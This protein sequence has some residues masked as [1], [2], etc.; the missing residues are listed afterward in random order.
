[1]LAGDV[2]QGVAIPDSGP[3]RPWTA[4]RLAEFAEYY[5]VL[6]RFTLRQIIAGRDGSEIRLPGA[7]VGAARAGN[8]RID[9]SYSALAARSDLSRLTGQPLQSAGPSRALGIAHRAELSAAVEATLEAIRAQ[10]PSPATRAG[11]DRLFRPRGVWLIDLHAAA[12]S[13]ARAGSP[14]ITLEQSVPA[15]MA[16]GWVPRDTVLAAATVAQALYRL[17]ALSKTDSL[18]A[19]GLL[20]GMRRSALASALAVDALLGGYKVAAEWH[21]AVLRFLLHEPWLASS[22]ASGN[23]HSLGDLMRTSWAGTLDSLPTPAVRAHLF[24]YPQAVPRYG[25]PAPLFDRLVRVENWPARQWLDR[26]GAPALLESLRLLTLDFGTTASLEAGDESFR[27]TSVRR[28]ALES[29][30]GFLEPHDAIL[31]DPGYVPLLALGAV[32]HEWQHLAFE[33]LRRMTPAPAGNVVELPGIDPFIAEGVAEWRTER[34]LAP[35]LDRFPLLGFGEA[36]KRARLAAADADEH[37]VLGY[38]MVRALAYEVPDERRLHAIL[39]TAADDPASAASM[40]EVRRAWAAYSQSPDLVIPVQGRQ[41]LIP[42][43]T[44][45]VEDRYPDILSTRI[46]L[47]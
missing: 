12:V 30:N 45:T 22:S 29:M 6:P 43:T 44:F 24:G 28:Q 25:V 17:H 32:V 47:P 18:A 40:P 38:A 23:G 20:D 14:A 5:P 21:S 27:L 2:L 42:E 10:I 4:A 15:L 37:H 46:I 7:W 35:L 26:H 11:Y 8:G 39:L 34:L 13:F 33:R 9:S 36:E 41:V 3:P 31:V 1:M 19:A 16:V